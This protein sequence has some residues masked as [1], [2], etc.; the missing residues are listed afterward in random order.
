[1][2]VDLSN[3]SYVKNIAPARTFGFL[4][5]APMLRNMGLIRG[6]TEENASCSRA[7]E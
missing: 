3:G 7:K 5:E 2:E 4:H 1:M 6:A